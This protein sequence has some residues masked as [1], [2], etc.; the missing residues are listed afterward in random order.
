METKTAFVRADGAIELHTVT[1][2]SLHF[3]FV[4]NPGYTESEDTVRL[5]ETLYDFCLFKFRM[6]VVNF[7]DRLENLLNCLKVLFFLAVL[8]LKL[9]HNF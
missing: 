9:S 6:L 5:H 8:R 4:V 3:A 2:V 1:E 7:L